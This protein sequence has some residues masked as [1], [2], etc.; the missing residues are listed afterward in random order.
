MGCLN[1]NL[2]P[3]L[4][5]DDGRQAACEAS[6]G[7]PLVHAWD[8]QLGAS[9]NERQTH[10][11]GVNPPKQPT[12]NRITFSFSAHAPSLMEGGWLATR[13]RKHPCSF[14][15]RLGGGAWESNWLSQM[16][17]AWRHMASLNAAHVGFLH[18]VATSTSNHTGPLP[19]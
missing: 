6:C 11:H 9:S 8:V 1:L 14:G 3:D 12:C 15:A 7:P 16:I 5:H 4:G 17:Q 2:R 18:V 19:S 10:R 13:P